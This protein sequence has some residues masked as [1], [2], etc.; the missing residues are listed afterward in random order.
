MKVTR[1][2]G[3]SLAARDYAPGCLQIA[4]PQAQNPS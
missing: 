4:A 1:R 3:R 2:G